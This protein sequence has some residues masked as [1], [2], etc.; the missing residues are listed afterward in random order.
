MEPI[1]G[2]RGCAGELASQGLAAWELLHGNDYPGAT[3][4]KLGR[5]EVAGGWTPSG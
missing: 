2:G 3:A 1:H 5:R 4:R